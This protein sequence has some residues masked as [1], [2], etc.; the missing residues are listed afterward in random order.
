MSHRQATS[1][2]HS[3]TLLCAAVG[4][5]SDDRNVKKMTMKRTGGLTDALLALDQAHAVEKTT[6]IPR[7][8][9][10]ELSGCG[11][12]GGALTHPSKYHRWFGE[13]GSRTYALTPEG[14]EYV[15]TLKKSD[16]GTG[17]VARF[18]SADGID[19][20]I[21]PLAPNKNES[22]DRHLVEDINNVFENPRIGATE[23]VAQ[24]LARIGQGDFRKRV[25]ELWGNC[26][27][28][29]RSKTQEAIRASHIKPWRES[30]NVERLDPDNGLPLLASLDALF[31]TGLISFASSGAMLVSS[32]L[33]RS[34]KELFGVDD[35]S[36]TKKPTT[37]TAAYL[38]YHRDNCFQE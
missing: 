19:K 1:F 10:R 24:I 20:P 8:K 5:V 27:A 7:K 32:K 29:T 15:K 34:E 12:F 9:I 6:S 18:Q 33:N 26:C 25:L 17:A 16:S 3:L 22:F 4:W 21:T 2:R 11:E 35:R 31:D 28:V 23:K 36:L 37:K 38:A 14:V 13:R 30:N